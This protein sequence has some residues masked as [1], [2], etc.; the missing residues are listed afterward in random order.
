M[1]G[2]AEIGNVESGVGIEH[3]DEGDRRKMKSFGNHLRA[4]EDV[5]FMGAKLFEEIFV[6]GFFRGG[7]SV[8]AERA[9]GGEEGVEG[10]FDVLCPKPF[11][12]ERFRGVAVW[13]CSRGAEP[14]VAEVALEEIFLKV[15]GEG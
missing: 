8:H 1:F 2:G 15:E 5:G 12:V 7:V 13:A 11:E 9:D 4:D 3:A 14:I 10:S 6:A